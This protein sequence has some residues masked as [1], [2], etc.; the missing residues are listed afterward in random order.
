MEYS[1]TVYNG[2]EAIK[3]TIGISSCIITSLAR[4]V[5]LGNTMEELLLY[6]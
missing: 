2:L 5:F 1:E 4:I 3:I 6:E